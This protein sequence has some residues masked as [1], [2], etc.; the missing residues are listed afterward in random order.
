MASIRN[1]GP[2]PESPS[3]SIDEMYNVAAR[4][5]R[6]IRKSQPYQSQNKKHKSVN[7]CYKSVKWDAGK[8]G[9]RGTYTKG[10]AGGEGSGGTEGEAGEGRLPE[11]E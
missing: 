11:F 2:W 3:S 10:T 6:S 1:K 4:V 8:L 9:P 5:R 7:V